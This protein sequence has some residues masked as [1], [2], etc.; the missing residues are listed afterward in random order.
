MAVTIWAAG[1]VAAGGLVALDRLANM[2]V[3]PVHRAA[4]RPIGDLGIPFEEIAIA[5]GSR[6]LAAWL[7]TPDGTPASRVLVVLAHG[8]G[9]NHGTVVDLAEPLLR[10]GYPVLLFDV[11]GHGRS[12]PVPY[13]TVRQFRDDVRA[14]V[15]HAALHLPYTAR[16]V[17]GHSM[18]AAGALLAAAEGA[19]VHGVV[20]IAGPA[21]VL[22]ISA[23]YLDERGWPG[24]AM[25][26]LL[27]PFWWW[28]AGSGF[29]R[30]TPERRAPDV[31]VPLLL[32]QPGEDSRVPRG[33]A[34]RLARAA[35]RPLHV[36]EGTRHTDV[37]RHPETH[38][39]VLDFLAST[40]SRMATPGS[41]RD[42]GGA[43]SPVTKSRT[44]G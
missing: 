25:V 32:V 33:H 1:A 7:L 10:A 21:D 15:R 17:A 16:V 18:G 31:R 11:R 36:I 5:S 38:R 3:R 12:E 34:E 28:R 19:P 20:S 27:R 42:D 4:L 14:V 43:P 29:A 41:G 23:A 37:L 22:E 40:T 39:L 30:L 8:W 6:R 24:G 2:V 35:D 13:V 44:R 26:W 9:A